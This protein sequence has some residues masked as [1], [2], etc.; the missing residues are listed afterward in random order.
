MTWKL[1][2]LSE[3]LLEREGRIKS[4]T[5]NALG[6]QRIKKIDFSGLIH[7]QTETDTKT[8]MIRIS[9]GDLVISGINA[10]KGA[11]AV[12]NG[13]EDVLATIH[14]SAYEFNPDR[15]SIEYLNW[16]FKS[17]EFSR[18]L[19]EQVAGGI[20]TELKA[21][22]LLKLEIRLPPLSEQIRIAHRLSGL[23]LEQLR[24]ELEIRNQQS[25]IA[26]FKQSVLNKALQG[27][28]TKSWRTLNPS[29]VTAASWLGCMNNKKE[30]SSR[31]KGAK[32]EKLLPNIDESEIPFVIPDSWEWCRLGA[33]IIE[34]PRNG[35]S[36]K[37]VE[38][39]TATKTLK[40]SATTSGSF[41]G[42]QIKY[43]EA[44]IEDDSHLW[45]EDGDILIQRANS[46]ELVGTSAVYR[47]GSHEYI[48]PDLMMK[49]RPIDSAA[50]EYIHAALSAKFTKDYFQKNATG[51]AGN[52][53]KINQAT[54]MNTLIPL[55][56]AA[57]LECIM[58]EISGL[59]AL[60]DE[61]T[62]TVEGNASHLRQLGDAV[63]YEAFLL[64]A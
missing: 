56:P 48:Y 14:Y 43:L 58:Q 1:T 36:L 39:E 54:V 63:L 8:D 17:P 47:G 49:C 18:L 31:A 33:L 46:M 3:F 13:D 41:D 64:A 9:Q 45:L 57:E 42:T 11:I 27:E 38:Y 6:L 52:M 30:T 32:A 55:P 60:I 40:L 4:E 22:H 25:L 50:T 53:P 10:A 2:K 34:K 16:F 61:L 19:K 35:L 26:Q 5:A 20:K 7:L 28:L 29:A 21:K 12:Y 37:P 44:E 15:I 62:L 23:H 59:F 24:V 51:A